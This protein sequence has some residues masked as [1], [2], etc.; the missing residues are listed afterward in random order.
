MLTIADDAPTLAPGGSLTAVDGT[1]V[2]R[3]VTSGEVFVFASGGVLG[4]AAP[5]TADTLQIGD[6][7]TGPIT[8]AGAF[9]LGKIGTLDLESGGLITE[10]GAGAVAVGTLTG[11]AGAVSLNGPNRIATLGRFSTIGPFALSNSLGLAGF[12]AGYGR[13][14][15]RADRCG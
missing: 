9:D 7:T 12:G 4:I 3:P 2:A 6:P 13:R 8:I 10:T 1:I 11:R 14:R 15:R 5:I